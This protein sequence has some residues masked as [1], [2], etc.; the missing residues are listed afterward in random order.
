MH[1][2]TRASVAELKQR[3]KENV[4]SESY[5]KT[6]NSQPLREATN[7]QILTVTK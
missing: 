3:L 4:A 1:L 6:S 5:S 7:L 2:I